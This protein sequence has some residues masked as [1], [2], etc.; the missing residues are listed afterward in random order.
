MYVDEVL[1]YYVMVFTSQTAARLVFYANA[2]RMITFWRQVISR[3]IFCECDC[4]CS[5][6]LHAN[7]CYLTSQSKHSFVAWP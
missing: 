2:T 4:F 7:I 3:R 5:L 6:Y 1:C